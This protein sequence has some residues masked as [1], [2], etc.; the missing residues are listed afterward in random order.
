MNESYVNN[1]LRNELVYL[2]RHAW[3]ITIGLL[4]YVVLNTIK[5]IGFLQSVSFLASEV[6]SEYEI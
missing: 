3:N 5:R 4:W 2:K 6:A 1:N